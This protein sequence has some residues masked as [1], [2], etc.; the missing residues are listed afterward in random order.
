MK[1]MRIF[2]SLL[3]S[4]FAIVLESNA[5]SGFQMSLPDFYNSGAIG[6]IGRGQINEIVYSPDGQLL[7]VG[8]SIGTWLYDAESGKELALLTAHTGGVTSVAFSPDGKTL[9]TVNYVRSILLW[10][11]KTREHKATLL[12]S[13]RYIAFSPD[14]KTLAGSNGGGI[15]FWDVESLEQTHRIAARAQ[16]R[17][18]FSPNSTSIASADIDDKLRVWDTETGM[19]RLKFTLDAFADDAIAYS[20]DGEALASVGPNHTIQIWDT[21]TGMNKTTLIG[22]TQHVH[23]V[24]YSPNSKTLAS[25]GRDQTVRLWD[26]NTSENKTTLTGHKSTVD[27]LAISPDGLTLVSGSYDGTIQFWDIETGK[28]KSTL[29]HA[30]HSVHAKLSPDGKT[31]ATERSEEI[32]LWDVKT[33]QQ[34]AILTGLKKSPIFLSF[35]KDGTSIIGMNTDENL[36]WDT[37]TAKQIESSTFSY[38]EKFSYVAPYTNKR[39]FSPDGTTLASGRKDGNVEFWDTHTRKRKMILERTT[40]NL[41]VIKFSPDGSILVVATAGMLEFWDTTTGKQTATYPK[42]GINPSVLAISRDNIMI[43]GGE[44]G[45]KVNLWN[46]KTDEH[47]SSLG[48]HTNEGLNA[49]SS[50][51]FSADGKTLAT[52]SMDLTV[53][54]WDTA[55]GHHLQTFGGHP[56]R[57]GGSYGGITWLTFSPTEDILFS[58]SQDGTIHLWDATHTVESDATVSILPLSIN[59]PA[60][61]EQFSLDVTIADTENIAGYEITLEYDPTVLRYVS[62]NKGDY[63]TENA[64]FDIEERRNMKVV[65]FHNV[66]YPHRLKLTSKD[67]KGRL[68]EGKGWKTGRGKE[69]VI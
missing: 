50:L 37:E 55:T 2:T 14:G 65:E 27:T 23:T 10:D 60:V 39:T 9:A 18:V 15:T 35:S 43:A 25:G 42:P 40:A 4:V 49:I 41:S 29:R 52:G 66:S 54:L 68:E 38:Q 67:E 44:R 56:R 8:S 47:L 63:L 61:G 48:H 20:P 33:G 22:H 13:V 34:K 11:M 17:I 28:H 6:R 62:A 46:I 69:M 30:Q 7:A 36:L 53:R 16:R 58:R 3:L 24:V 45:G 64:A 51:A 26:L 59:S 57:I 12:G 21:R 31:L 19:N 1:R 5:Q 32:T